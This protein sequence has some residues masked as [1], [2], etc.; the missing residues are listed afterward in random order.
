M[1]Q[2]D[3]LT[4]QWID[5]GQIRSLME[6][7]ALASKRQVPD[8]VGATMLPGYDVLDMVGKVGMFLTE[9]T[10]FTMVVRAR[11]HKIARRRVHC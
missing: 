2:R 11:A 9:K 3:R 4:A 7:A 6:I 8:S 5:P 10:V 1:K